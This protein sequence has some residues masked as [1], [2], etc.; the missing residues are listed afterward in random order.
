MTFII[1]HLIYLYIYKVKSNIVYS[2]PIVTARVADNPREQL[3]VYFNIDFSKN[4]YNIIYYNSKCRLS[5]LYS[6]IH[7]THIYI[8]TYWEQI[9]CVHAR[10]PSFTRIKNRHHCHTTTA[11]MC[12]TITEAHKQQAVVRYVYS[13]AYRVDR[14]RFLFCNSLVGK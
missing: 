5:R 14:R 2:A 10:P 9:V 4:M 8:Y 12:T 1:F 13:F 6:S 7:I 3:H 11:P